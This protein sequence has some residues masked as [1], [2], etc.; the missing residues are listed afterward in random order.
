MD[1]A[2]ARKGVKYTDSSL[3][4]KKTEGKEM[5][6]KSVG[7]RKAKLHTDTVSGVLMEPGSIHKQGQYQQLNTSSTCVRTV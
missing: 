1:E 3:N 5:C 7:G 6:G 2:L 4:I